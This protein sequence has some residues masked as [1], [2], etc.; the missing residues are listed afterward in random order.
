[1]TTTYDQE[2]AMSRF[3]VPE[4]FDQFDDALKLDP[5][6]RD[7]AIEIHNTI[8]ERLKD[9]AVVIGGFL[10]GS[11]ARKTMLAPLRDIDKV[12]L[13]E[14]GPTDQGPGSARRA[15]EAVSTAL[16]SLSTAYTV[17]IGKHCVKLE[18]A[19]ESFSFDIV[20]AI[21]LGDDVMIVDTEQ[22]RWERSNTREL[23]RVVQDLNRQCNGRWVRQVRFAKEFVRRNLDGSVPGLHVE[24]FAHAAIDKSMPHDEALAA[25]FRA[26]AE[27]LAP[28]ATYTDPTGVDRLDHRLEARV[29]QLAL[30]EF[31][32]AA[33]RA[34]EAVAAAKRGEQNAALGIWHDLLGD[35][36]PKPDEKAVF[37]ALG[38]GVGVGAFN[39]VS[40]KASVK[41][42]NTRAWRQAR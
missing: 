25:I 11:F 9:A 8:T 33:G 21:D 30:A 35:K 40:R 41:T 6:E 24:A 42:P 28:E 12:L 29:R 10:Q 5:D 32:K 13:L 39:T 14:W 17:D 22:D 23:I 18:F 2:V 20:P 15:A 37:G 4:A 7:R 36:F 27:A 16:R 38:A 34:D 26:A 3:T 19:N 1:M 31:S